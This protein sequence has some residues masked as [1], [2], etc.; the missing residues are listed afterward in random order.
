[1]DARCRVEH[2]AQ[3][4][5]GRR[6]AQSLLDGVCE[7]ERVQCRVPV[8]ELV[9]GGKSRNPGRGRERHRRGGGDL[10]GA[11]PKRLEQRLDDRRGIVGEQRLDELSPSRPCHTAAAS[12]GERFGQSRERLVDERH[13]VDRVSPAVRLLHPLSA[14]EL[15]RERREHSFGAIPPGEV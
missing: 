13:E 4:L 7:R 3:Q 11:A 14:R 6:P 15:S 8:A 1:M 2:A 12:R 9:R 10:A 5:N